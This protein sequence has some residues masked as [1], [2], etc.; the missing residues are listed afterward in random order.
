[1][2]S[3]DLWEESQAQSVR[4]AIS[5]PPQMGGGFLEAGTEVSH[6]LALSLE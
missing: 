5:N 3:A 4:G 2:P 1:M 6:F